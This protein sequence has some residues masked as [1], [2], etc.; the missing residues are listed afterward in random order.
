ME[1]V[2]ESSD[3]PVKRALPNRTLDNARLWDSCVEQRMELQRCNVCGEFWYYPGPICPHCSAIDFSWTPISGWGSVHTFTWVHWAAP[4]WE[5]RV[6]YVYALV[7]LD[8]GPILATNIVGTT[9]E[10]LAIGQRVKLHYDEVTPDITLP[11]FAPA[12]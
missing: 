3:V 10:S 1:D 11:L 7:E 6:P 12:E 2:D 8:E 4:G 5:D 9:P